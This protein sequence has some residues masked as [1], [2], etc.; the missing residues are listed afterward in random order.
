MG[1]ALRWKAESLHI[2]HLALWKSLRPS[3]LLFGTG[4]KPL[5]LSQA[6]KDELALFQIPYETLSTKNAV[7]TYSVLVEENRNAGLICL[8]C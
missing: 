2:D 4:L 3:I 1:L 8:P 5:F 7:A 6:F